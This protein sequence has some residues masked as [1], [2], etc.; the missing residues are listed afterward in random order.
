MLYFFSSKKKKQKQK[1]VTVLLVDNGSLRPSSYLSLCNMASS[2]AQLTGVPVIPASARFADK[3][4]PKDL[5]GRSGEI[6]SGVITR[7]ASEGE[8]HFLILPAFLGPSDTLKSLVPA[9]FSRLASTYP[10][11]GFSLASPLVRLGSLDGES[12]NRV[13]QALLEGVIVTM[14]THGLV[15]EDTAVI[16]CDHGSPHP[17][18]AAVRGHVAAQ[19]G[20]LLAH[21]SR[22]RFRAPLSEASMERRPGPEFDFNEPLLEKVL[23]REPYDRGSVVLALLFLSPGA[24]AGPGGDIAEIARAAMEEAGREGRSLNVF[25]TPLLGPKVANIL[26]DR[27]KTA[28]IEFDI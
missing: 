4:D 17:D 10:G 18:V 28:L 24:H 15:P 26:A 8:R 7:L 1:G 13:A 23:R 16:L 11:L 19:L 25:T 20:A 9:T 14:A 12:D 22:P 6:L 27:L 3:L 5:D 2:V 21:P